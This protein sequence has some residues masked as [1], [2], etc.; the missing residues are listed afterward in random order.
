[1]VKIQRICLGSDRERFFRMSHL[2]RV[3]HKMAPGYLLLNFESISE[4]HSNNTRGSV[5]NDLNRELSLSQTGSA[6]QA[7]KQ[8]NDLPDDLK[9]I[10]VFSEFLNGSF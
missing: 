6:F 3:R 1:M 5:Q 9:S 2:Y 10:K 4:A 8:W 7:I